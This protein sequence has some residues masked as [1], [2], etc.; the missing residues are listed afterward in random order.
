MGRILGEHPKTAEGHHRVYTGKGSF[1]YCLVK[2]T[3]KTFIHPKTFRCVLFKQAGLEKERVL[4][5]T[6]AT[7]AEAQVSEL[8]EYIDK[9]LGR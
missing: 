3:T 8:Q 7:V 4:L 5:I 6:R 9:H 2:T 1:F